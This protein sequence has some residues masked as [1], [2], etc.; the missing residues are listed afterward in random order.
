MSKYT[1]ALLVM[2]TLV[3]VSGVS[4]AAPTTNDGSLL[5]ALTEIVECDALGDCVGVLPEEVGLPNFVVIDLEQ[6]KLLEARDEG[7][8]STKIDAISQAEG[9]VAFGGLDHG[10]GWSAV[11]SGENR[12]L[13]ATVTG[14]GAGFVVFGSCINNP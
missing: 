11:L 13:S 14:D 6:K 10:R 3:G 5:C 12:F 1:T 7:L 8:R 4:Y 2:L 9:R